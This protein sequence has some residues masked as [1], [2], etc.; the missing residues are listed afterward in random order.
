[1]PGEPAFELMGS[2]A[3]VEGDTAVG[4]AAWQ[5]QTNWLEDSCHTR[6]DVDTMKRTAASLGQSFSIDNGQG[7]AQ[8]DGDSIV[9]EG[10]ADVTALEDSWH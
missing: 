7:Q 4:A 8:Q 2:P 6:L 5:R 1:M 10:R 3:R 9:A